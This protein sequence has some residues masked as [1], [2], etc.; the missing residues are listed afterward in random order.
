MI[1]KP[2]LYTQKAF[3]DYVE[4]TPA[5][6][7]QMVKEDNLPDG[8]RLIKIKGGFIIEVKK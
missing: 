3:A 4:L 1:H 5:R 8:T 2:N 7:N 6:V